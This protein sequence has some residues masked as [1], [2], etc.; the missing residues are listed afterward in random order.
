MAS[1][2]AASAAATVRMKNTKTWPVR[3]AWKYEKATKFML[4][5]SSISSIAMSRMM[6]FFR[7]RKI[8]ATLRQNTMAPNAR[9]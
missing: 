7:L 4:T 9:K 3:S 1:P 5:D 2:M 8:P 6:T